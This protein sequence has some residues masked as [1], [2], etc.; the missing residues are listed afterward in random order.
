MYLRMYLDSVVQKCK[1]TRCKLPVYIL[2]VHYSVSR[3]MQFVSLFCS[4]SSPF[5][6]LLI[7]RELL[8]CILILEVMYG[9]VVEG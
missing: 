2:C 4:T 3:P 9:I 1:V 7:D 5:L 6:L 8:Q